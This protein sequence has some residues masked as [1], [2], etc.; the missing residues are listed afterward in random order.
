MILINLKL[1]TPILLHKLICIKLH[2]K[3]FTSLN[4]ANLP[5]RQF[6]SIQGP[7]SFDYI[8]SNKF[9]QFRIRLIKKCKINLILFFLIKG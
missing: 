4:Y 1:N 8:Q 2:C 6:I 7:D 5:S 9:F 3:N